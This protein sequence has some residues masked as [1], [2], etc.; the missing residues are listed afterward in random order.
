M[1][2][3]GGVGIAQQ[4]VD[5]LCHGCFWARRLSTHRPV[6]RFPPDDPARQAVG[7]RQL[8]VQTVGPRHQLQP[9]QRQS[10]TSAQ[11][12]LPVALAGPAVLGGEHQY[13][14][15]PVAQDQQVSSG[16][17][18]AQVSAP[19][20]H[21]GKYRAQAGRETDPAPPAEH[22]GISSQG[23]AEK[24]RGP[25]SFES[26]AVGGLWLALPLG[27]VL[28]LAAAAVRGGEQGPAVGRDLQGGLQGGQG[29]VVPPRG[30]G[31]S[32]LRFGG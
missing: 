9:G 29:W 31:D 16:Q 6:H 8:P 25:G 10:I 32:K 12:L 15:S 3:V 1:P 14:G 13:Q 2:A 18:H 21:V 26:L 20:I 17:E 30:V 4:G 28:L 23:I 11:G 22:A 19:T 7:H 5:L 24:A 27:Q